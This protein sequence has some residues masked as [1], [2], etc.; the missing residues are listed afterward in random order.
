[1][2]SRAS[3]KAAGSRFEREVADYLNAHVSRYIDRKV[4]TG[5]KD[6]GDIANV[7][8][9]AVWPGDGRV[10]V[11]CKDS[12]VTKLG[13]WAAEAEAERIND[14]ALIGVVVHKRHGKADPADQW[15]TCTLRDF[16]A[17][18][19]GVRPSDAPPKEGNA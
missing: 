18:L 7:Y 4:K 1:M 12:A 6:C 5:A 3:A 17:L 13:P 19:S 8:R 2:R 15:V 16:A 14:G 10:V 11:E 9:L